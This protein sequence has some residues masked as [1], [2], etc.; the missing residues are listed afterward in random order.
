[1][2]LEY[3]TSAS[4]ESFAGILNIFGVMIWSL[5]TVTPRAAPSRC[6]KRPTSI[7]FFASYHLYAQCDDQQPGGHRHL[8]RTTWRKHRD[9][10][11]K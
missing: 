10:K 11:A 9:K 4:S 7:F 6:V 8:N 2:S 3:F 1:V 5:L